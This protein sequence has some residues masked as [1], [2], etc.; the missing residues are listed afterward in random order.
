MI[1][2][3]TIFW[4]HMIVAGLLLV[5]AIVLFTAYMLTRHLYAGMLSIVG[6]SLAAYSFCFAMTEF[7]LPPEQAR[8]Y[9]IFGRAFLAMSGVSFAATVA[10]YLASGGDELRMIRHLLF[11]WDWFRRG[12]S[13]LV[14]LVVLLALLAITSACTAADVRGDWW[15]PQPKRQDHTLKLDCTRW[16]LI[17]DCE[18]IWSRT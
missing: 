17:E 12:G 8:Y 18:P 7:P 13:R 6:L 9:M 16:L 4:F 3:P 14:V 11:W 2:L 5:N 10:L 15:I 1:Y